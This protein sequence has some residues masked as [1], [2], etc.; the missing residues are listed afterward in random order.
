MIAVGEERKYNTEDMGLK[1][2]N[3]QFVEVL[4]K[5]AEGEMCIADLGNMYEIRFPDG[6]VRNAFEA[7]LV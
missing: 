7:E 4:R 3:G 2:R 5:L 1:R 6:Y